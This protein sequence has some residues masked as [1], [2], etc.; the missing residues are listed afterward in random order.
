MILDDI[1]IPAAVYK[2]I[3]LLGGF[4]VYFLQI[5]MHLNTLLYY[6]QSSLPLRAGLLKTAGVRRWCS[7]AAHIKRKD[8]ILVKTIPMPEIV[9]SSWENFLS[10]HAQD[11]EMELFRKH[12]RTGRPKG[13]D[14]FIERMEKLL[15]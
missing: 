2:A 8:D 7:A 13:D 5:L 15:D 9:N 14:V 11:S 12:E 3:I 6:R 10:V 1:V 4:P